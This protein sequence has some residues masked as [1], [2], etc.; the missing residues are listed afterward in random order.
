MTPYQLGQEV[1]TMRG[2]E[3]HGNKP[4]TGNTTSDDSMRL[5]TVISLTAIFTLGSIQTSMLQ[6]Q[7]YLTPRR[8]VLGPM[9]PAPTCGWLKTWV[10]PSQSRLSLSTCQPPCWCSTCVTTQHWPASNSSVHEPELGCS[11]ADETSR[12][13]KASSHSDLCSG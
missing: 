4:D 13:P 10:R 6:L 3:Y 1:V 8:K 5:L 7:L 11:L 9:S 2:R 12:I